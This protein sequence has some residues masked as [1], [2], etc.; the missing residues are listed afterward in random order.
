MIEILKL[1]V[2]PGVI[3]L[4]IL[5]V[6]VG[7]FWIMCA[8]GAFEFDIFTFDGGDG[9]FDSG[10]SRGLASGSNR[11][12]IR[13][14]NGD[15]VPVSVILSLWLV[16]QWCFAM[17]GHHVRPPDGIVGVLTL[18]GVGLLPA[19]ALTKLTTRLLRPWFRVIQGKEGEAKP[20]VG[21]LGWV[22]S[23]V[24]DEFSGQ[25]EVDDPESPLLINARARAGVS[26]IPRGARVLVDEHHPDSGFYHVIPHNENL[27]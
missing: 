22:R 23:G 14:L 10:D 12:L 26:P 9:G 15:V 24:C 8:I 7:F 2:S 20:V 5:L 13:F 1:S 21:R 4:S 18:H 27:S 11:W 19:V 6:M 16:Y 3:P 17:I 25:V